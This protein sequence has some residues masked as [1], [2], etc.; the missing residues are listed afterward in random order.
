M[1]KPYLKLTATEKRQAVLDALH[2]HGGLC[3]GDLKILLGAT[4]SLSSVLNTLHM[5]GEIEQAGRI[6]GNKVK[7]VA[8]VEK[9]APTTYGVTGQKPAPEAEPG[10]DLNPLQRQHYTLVELSK[11]KNTSRGGQCAN[12]GRPTMQSGMQMLM[13]AA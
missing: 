1:A 4:Q 2:A 7:W 5:R 6:T 8:V 11:K 12:T 10:S 3:L 13:E 9:T